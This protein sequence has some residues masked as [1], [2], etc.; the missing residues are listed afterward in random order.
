MSFTR[1]D[2]YRE[3]RTTA[4]C[5]ARQLITKLQRMARLWDDQPELAR[6]MVQ[7]YRLAARADVARRNFPRR[8]TQ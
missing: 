7:L 2:A 3:L 6:D 8:N 4:S 5:R 1:R